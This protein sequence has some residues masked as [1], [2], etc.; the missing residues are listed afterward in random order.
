MNFK[1]DSKITR[2]LNQNDISSYLKEINKFPLLAHEEEI[3]LASTWIK[4]KCFNS[5]HKLINSHL[6]LVVKLSMIIL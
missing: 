4:D 3:E 6:R 1:I 2:S 5:A